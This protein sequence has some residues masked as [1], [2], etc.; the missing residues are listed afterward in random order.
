MHLSWWISQIGE[1]EIN[2]QL[3]SWEEGLNITDKKIKFEEAENR[4]NELNGIHR[5]LEDTLNNLE[6]QIST[7]ENKLQN[8]S[9]DFKEEIEEEQAQKVM[10]WVFIGLGVLALVGICWAAL[11]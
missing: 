8:C 4:L 6:E 2:N 10:K 7:L 11:M 3:Q 1:E 9:E 5:K